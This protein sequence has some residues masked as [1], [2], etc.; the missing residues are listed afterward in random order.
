MRKIKLNILGLS[1]SQTQS[2]AYALVL[3]EE[4][5][6]RRIPI[7][8]GAVEAQAI[9]IQLEGLK[10]PRPLTHDLFLNTALAFHINVVEV[11]IH[12]LE[13]GIFYAELVCQQ[14]GNKITV[15]SRTSDAVALALRFECPIYTT[16]DILDKAGIILDFEEE[17]SSGEENPDPEK[18]MVGPEEDEDSDYSVYSTEE[19]NT[20]LDKAVSEEDYEKASEIRDEIQRR[21]RKK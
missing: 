19:L 7:I 21:K 3:S 5:G 8:I 17:E 1:Y 4:D 18:E 2:G 10:P 9:A 16:E 13:E 12:K 20:M 11:F 6:N 14:N 15:D